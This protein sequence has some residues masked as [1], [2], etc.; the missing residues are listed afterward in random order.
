MGQMTFQLSPG[1]P[2]DM[3]R[4][5]ERACLAG[6]FD[7]AP[8]PTEVHHTPSHLTVA[9]QLDESGYLITPWEVA[10]VG[11]LMTTTATLIERDE[12]YS[13]PLEIARGKVHQLRNH[14]A[15][16]PYLGF[17]PLPD[18]EEQIRALSRSFGRAAAA[19]FSEEG[20]KSAEECVREAFQL[21]ES[22]V[23]YYT[24]RLFALRH[25]RSPRLDTILGCQ[26]S[27]LPQDREPLSAFNALRLALTWRDIEPTESRYDWERADAVL[28]W[29][30][31]NDVPVSGGPLIDLSRAGLPD[32]LWLWEGDLSNLANFMC[33]YVETAIARYRGRI[34]RWLLTTGCNVCSILSLA[35]DDMLWLTARLAEAAVQM[36]PDIELVL[37]VAQPWG[38]YLAREEHTYTP[39]MFIDTLLRAGLKIA[40]IDLELL[41][42]VS[43]RGS[44]CRD[45]LEVCR[46]LD[47][48]A[49]L[50]TPVQVT[51]SYP[52]SD[53]PDPN[54]DGELRFDA[55][56]WGAGFTPESQADWAAKFAA[57]A[58][59]KPYVGGVYWD[60]LVDADRHRCPNGGLLD[61][62]GRPRP[63]LDE[64]RRLRVAH[65]K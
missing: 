25:Q 61:G 22:L 13:A 27:A 35:E 64:L 11:R 32:W 7:N 56:R 50:S 46:M 2:A 8:T 49:V 44:Y 1:L 47:Q 48:Y 63:A 18:H 52:S 51:L 9:R 55:G 37:G 19:G 29:A 5:L 38:E 4:E 14:V 23:P 20:L 54:G 57:L 36:S 16:W 21:S 30:A 62:A 10:G 53:A 59:C 39:L 60:H 12:P 15:E 34:K 28:E 43:P 3:P 41:M 31:A 24:D 42:G 58:L 17:N 65:L 45:Q 40:A 33:D 26:L 6:G